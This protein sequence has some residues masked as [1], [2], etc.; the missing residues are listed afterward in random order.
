MKTTTITNGFGTLWRMA[1]VNLWIMTALACVALILS[2]HAVR[3]E[4]VSQQQ[5]MGLDEQVQ[6]IKSDVLT[7]AAELKHLE[8][9][10]LFPSGSQVSAFLSLADGE[11]FRLDAVEIRINGD[12]VAY[13][14]YSFKELEALRDGGLQR[15]Y[16]GN[17]STGEH[18]MEVSMT[19][20]VKGEDVFSRTESF[21]F[22]KTVGPEMIEISLAGPG[23][24]G[25]AISFKEL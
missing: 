17:V 19:G 18:V 7:I 23:S 21:S 13:H 3:A 15:I 5:V 20:K 12:P 10:L 8:E 25:E 9:K 14:L 2:A 6:E 1:S 16:T 22:S 11:G 24:N 4:E